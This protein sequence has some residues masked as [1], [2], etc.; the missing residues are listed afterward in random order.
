VKR[1]R[2][3]WQRRKVWKLNASE[4]KI[5]TRKTSRSK[6]EIKKLDV[7]VWRFE[8]SSPALFFQ[9]GHPIKE[10][11]PLKTPLSA[12]PHLPSRLFHSLPHVSAVDLSFAGAMQRELS[13]Y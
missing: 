2:Q 5:S 10:A 6:D 3:S 12:P 9:R 8:R 4:G 7:N 11:L 13:S 1:E